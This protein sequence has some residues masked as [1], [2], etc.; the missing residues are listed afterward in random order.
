MT[1]DWYALE[2]RFSPSAVA[3]LRALYGTPGSFT[4]TSDGLAKDTQVSVAEAVQF[5][6]T[7]AAGGSLTRR[8]SLRCAQCGTSLNDV[9]AR[10]ECPACR[11]SFDDLEP[12]RTVRYE[13][14][15]E[16]P[17]DVPWVLVLHGM[18]T[19][20]TWQEELS[21]LIG[22]S[23]RRMVPVAIYKYGIIRP[24]VLFRRRQRMLVRRLVAKILML[25]GQA[26]E[27]GYGGKPDVIAHSFGTWMIA[28]ALQSDPRVRIGRLVLL[29]CIVRP[30]FDWDALVQSGRVERIMNHGAAADIWVRLAH[31][32]IPD[33]GPGGLR[34]FPAPVENLSTARLSHSGYFRPDEQMRYFFTRNWQPFLS[35][36]TVPPL[37]DGTTPR[38]WRPLPW[39]VRTATRLLTIGAVAFIVA[40]VLVTVGMGVA[41]IVMALGFRL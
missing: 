37:P 21:W 39:P 34:G 7:L 25:S 8:E 41:A 9:G 13:L 27:S 6:Q 31:L 5:L 14:Q 20:G 1:P 22:R 10:D 4:L 35:W 11:T 23:Y 26:A 33:S 3:H 40:G 18:N 29:G 32:A 15:R 2:R 28:H 16:P 24:G 19:T 36:E 12:V 30:D 17:R 38:P